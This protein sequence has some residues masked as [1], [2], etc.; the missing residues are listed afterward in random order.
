MSLGTRIKT[1]RKAAHLTQQALADKTDV[2][3]IYIQALESNRRLPSMKL[4]GR[5]AQALAVE[6]TDLV[7]ASPT[8]DSGRI[9]LEEVLE[10]HENLEIWYKSKQLDQKEL[11]FI[12]GLIDTAI[13]FWAKKEV[14]EEA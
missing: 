4:L 9:H 10:N 5:L 14:T 11:L 8:D 3:R 1:L 13:S 2:S 6:V 12:R 7:K